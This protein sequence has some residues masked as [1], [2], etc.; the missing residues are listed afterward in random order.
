MLAAS[1]YQAQNE[2]TQQGQNE[3]ILLSYVRT[4]VRAADTAHAIFVGNH[5]GINALGI[6]EVLG[7]ERRDFITYIYYYD[8]W[9]REVF[10]EYGLDF[11][12]GESIAIIETTGIS[13]EDAHSGLIRVV[14][15]A[16][17]MY[18]YPRTTNFD[19]VFW[20]IAR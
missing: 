3:R 12:P 13:F 20:G 19:D 15:D 1:T 18:I 7:E 16:G 10:F 17:N 2:I 11:A 6:H 14:T 8:G 4:K 9:A 5:H